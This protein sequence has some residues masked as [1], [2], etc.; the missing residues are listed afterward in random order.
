MARCSAITAKGAR[1][2]GVPVHGSEL[3]AAHDPSTQAR[4]RTGAR[5]GGRSRGRSEIAELRDYLA[6]LARAVRTGELEPKIG[7]VVNQIVNSQ[8]R[9]L[10]LERKIAEQAEIEARLDALEQMQGYDAGAARW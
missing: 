8:L 2:K 6:A 7:A 1:C 5:R 3:C 9:A 4:R 10:E